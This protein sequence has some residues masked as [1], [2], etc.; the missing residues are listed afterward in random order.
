M[1][2]KYVKR[3]IIKQLLGIPLESPEPLHALREKLA[4]AQPKVKDEYKRLVAV[5]N[6][7]MLDV[8]PKK[9]RKAPAHVAKYAA[10]HAG[11]PCPRA[12]PGARHAEFL[13]LKA[14]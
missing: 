12:H 7:G 1:T 2:T 8:R 4:E 9:K 5:A 6:T 13:L 10:E 11:L 14:S 3:Q